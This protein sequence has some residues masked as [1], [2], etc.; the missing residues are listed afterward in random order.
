MAGCPRG[1]LRISATIKEYPSG[2]DV[3]SDPGHTCV[4]STDC[5]LGQTP[6]ECFFPGEYYVTIYGRHGSTLDEPKYYFT[7][8]SE[9][10]AA[11]AGVSATQ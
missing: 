9:D 3:W 8:T 7:V 4:N 6:Q 5:R 1:N 10:A 11:C 2:I